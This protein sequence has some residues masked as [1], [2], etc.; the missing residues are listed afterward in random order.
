MGNSRS[1]CRKCAYNSFRAVLAFTTWSAF[2]VA[3]A[4]PAIDDARTHYEKAEFDEA[5]ASLARAQRAD[6]LAKEELHDLVALRATVHFAMRKE[7]AYR[8]DLQVLASVAPQHTFDTQRPPAFRDAWARARREADPVDL[9]IEVERARS[10]VKFRAHVRGTNTSLVSDR[11]RVH[12]LL[13]D[14]TQRRSETGRLALQVPRP[15]T[16]KYWGKA[17]GPGNVV[18]AQ[19]GS[20]EAPHE[21]E[22]MTGAEH[23]REASSARAAWLVAGG[24]GAVAVGLA[25]ALGIVAA[26]K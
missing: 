19:T 26:N 24:S 6:T 7:S 17:M 11:L 21:V 5:L 12:A 3:Y 14:G 23:R 15:G 4:H 25:I 9:R 8:R 2:G 18:I 10:L 20:R 16:V 13:P 22:V 1:Q